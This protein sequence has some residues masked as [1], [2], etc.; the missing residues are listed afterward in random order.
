[1][2]EAYKV[3]GGGR[4]KDKII[5]PFRANRL[6]RHRFLSLFI[7]TTSK[8]WLILFIDDSYYEVVADSLK[9]C[10]NKYNVELLGY[11]FMPT[12]VHL[13]LFYNEK[14]EVSG[15][16]RDMKKYTSVKI[17][18]KL[19]EEGRIEVEKIK[20]NK[21]GHYYKVWKDRFDCVI[22]KNGKIQ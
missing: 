2:P 3:H 7:I 6:C 11:V 9:F 5:L 8:N 12:H 19:I 10:L 20:Y 4:N 16:M 22:I 18:D 14:S 21:N 17:R 13:I 1:M 15:F